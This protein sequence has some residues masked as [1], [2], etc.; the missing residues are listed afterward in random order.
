MD[1]MRSSDRYGLRLM[2]LGAVLFV[3]GL[4]SGFVTG[5]MENPR[6]GLSA[7]LQGITNG[8]FLLAAGAVWGRVQLPGT[9]KALAFW[10]FAAGT[11]GNWLT[12]QLAALWG[13]GSMMPL[14]APGFVAEPW[15]EQVVTAGLL[16]VSVTM[17]AGGVLLAA[18]LL[19][20]QR[21][22]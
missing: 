20:P 3:L 12:V 6:M 16:A 9:L 21:S 15:Q 13:A 17:L 5:A 7:H 10:L 1:E 22:Q 19:R 8:T 14:A 2:Q 11:T 18:G 4:L